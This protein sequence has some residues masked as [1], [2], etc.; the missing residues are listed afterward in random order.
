MR[1]KNE[2]RVQNVTLVNGNG[3][4]I[5]SLHQIGKRK[6]WF[7]RYK[8]ETIVIVLSLEWSFLMN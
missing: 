8:E 4:E 2:R 6:H 3:P 5:K 1:D 7:A